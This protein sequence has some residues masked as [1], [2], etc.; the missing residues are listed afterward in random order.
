MHAVTKYT[1]AVPAGTTASTLLAA[2][3]NGTGKV[4]RLRTTAG[5]TLRHMPYLA[6][7]TPAHATAAAITA[8]RAAGHTY[9]VLGAQHSLS[10]A[11]AQ[12]AVTN[13]WLTKAIASQPHSV[14]A[15]WLQAGGFTHTN[16][17]VPTAAPVFVAATNVGVAKPKATPPVATAPV[18][19]PNPQPP[20]WVPGTPAPWVPGSQRQ[21]FAT[22]SPASKATQPSKAK[23]TK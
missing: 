6:P 14:L 22:A 7:G 23:A 18:P 16:A 21:P 19:V 12:R 1:L 15:S 2:L 8:G 10:T 5:N 3:A 11:A 17:S 4:Y 13:L 9:T 20:L